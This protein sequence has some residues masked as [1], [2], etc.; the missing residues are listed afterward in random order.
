MGLWFWLHQFLFI[1]LKPF[2]FHDVYSGVLLIEIGAFLL[3]KDIS[4]KQNTHTLYVIQSFLNFW[5]WI[6]YF[7]SEIFYIPSEYLTAN[8]FI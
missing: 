4:A 2:T 8:T 1:A 6:F 3:D 7:S 5:N